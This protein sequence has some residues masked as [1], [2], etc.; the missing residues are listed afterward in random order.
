[1]ELQSDVISLSLLQTDLRCDNM[2][3]GSCKTNN[4]R[5]SNKLF[6]G[7]RGGYSDDQEPMPMGRGDSV[8][9]TFTP[10]KLEPMSLYTYMKRGGLLDCHLLV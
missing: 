3:P 8:C 10:L 4:A 9:F 1:M 7:I 6:C 2:M 5:I